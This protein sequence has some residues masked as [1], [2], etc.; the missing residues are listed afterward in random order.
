MRTTIILLAAFITLAAWAGG[1]QP[2]PAK[3]DAPLDARFLR[4]YAQ[5]RGFMLGR[6]VRPAPTP[7]GKAVLFLRSEPR[8][9]KLRLYEFDVATGKTRQ[10]LTPE[11]VLKGAQEKLS[12]EE[13]ARRERMRVSA[14]GFTNF[15]LSDDGKLILLSLAGK[16]YV[17]ERA[18]A[19]AGRG[20]APF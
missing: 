11:Q 13:K 3:K 1:Q 6:P 19:R 16:L 14:G 5:T 2:E 4:D 8:N 20:Q 9:A 17:I 10:I 15:H 12:P 18:T 7:D